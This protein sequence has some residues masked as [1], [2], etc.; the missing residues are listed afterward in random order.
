MKTGLVLVLIAIALSQLPIPHSTGR[1]QSGQPAN[2]PFVLVLPALPAPAGERI[3][4]EVMLD[5]A[6]ISADSNR[7][8]QPP[9]PS[10]HT[11]PE[12]AETDRQHAYIGWKGVPPR[13]RR[14]ILKSCGFPGTMRP[15]RTWFGLFVPMYQYRNGIETLI[16]YLF[17]AR[18]RRV[19]I[20][21]PTRDA[22]LLPAKQIW[23]RFASITWTPLGKIDEHCASAT[24]ASGNEGSASF[25]ATTS[26]SSP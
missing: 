18:C 8:G 13:S 24:S 25:T 26:L 5:Q 7:T 4:E 2:I 1:C 6:G 19:G 15:G 11:P 14:C 3:V 16:R 9:A 10:G 12:R 22:G 17:S 21:K 23:Y 20:G